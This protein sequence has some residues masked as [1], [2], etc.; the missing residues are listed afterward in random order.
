MDSLPGSRESKL[1]SL[2][3]ALSRADM[4]GEDRKRVAAGKAPVKRKKAIPDAELLSAPKDEATMLTYEREMIGHY[5]SDHPFNHVDKNGLALAKHS[6]MD[7]RELETGSQ[8]SVAGIVTRLTEHITKKGKQKMLF[9]A[10]EDTDSVLE[11]TVFPRDVSKVESVLK[12][13]APVILQGRVENDLNEDGTGFQTKILVSGCEKIAAPKRASIKTLV[14]KLT[15][16][17]YVS[18]I[19]GAKSALDEWTEIDF[20]LPD[21]SSIK[22]LP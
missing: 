20:R 16:D 22:V 4:L 2:E 5:L 6:I 19:R 15:E 1:A 12:L 8:A 11:F 21:G 17:D 18:Q 14:V 3:N 13:D 7:A 9:G 10:I